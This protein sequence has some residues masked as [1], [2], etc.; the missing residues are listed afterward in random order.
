MIAV[1]VDV[2]QTRCKEGRRR[3]STA[4]VSDPSDKRVMDKYAP[5]NLPAGAGVSWMCALLAIAVCC[6]L[7]KD[8]LSFE[9]GLWAAHA[10]AR[11]LILRSQSEAQ[12]GNLR[13]S[14]YAY[15]L[16]LD[17]PSETATSSAGQQQWIAARHRPRH[18]QHADHPLHHPSLARR[19]PSRPRRPPGSPLARNDPL[20]HPPRSTSHPLPSVGPTRQPHSRWISNGGWACPIRRSGSSSGRSRRARGRL[21]TSGT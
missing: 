14:L 7:W 1:R 3:T 18:Y 5:G 20:P 6:R 4:T 16:D 2:R 13:P 10:G 12:R 17:L 19:Q 9:G 8:P 15:P 11:V 21:R